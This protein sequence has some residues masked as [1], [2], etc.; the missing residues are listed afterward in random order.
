MSTIYYNDLGI[1]LLRAPWSDREVQRLWKRQ[2]DNTRHPYTCPDHG[3][4]ALEPLRDG[5]RCGVATCDYRQDWAHA[6]DVV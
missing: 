2:G 3:S 4:I 6:D 1:P 5:W